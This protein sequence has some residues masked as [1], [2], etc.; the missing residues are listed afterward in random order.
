[1]ERVQLPSNVTPVHYDLS[2]IPN[3]ESLSFIGSVRITV[4][5]HEATS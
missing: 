5:V 4:D 2:V 1:M 3:P